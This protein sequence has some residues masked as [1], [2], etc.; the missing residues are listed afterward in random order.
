[1]DASTI[2]SVAD[3]YLRQFAAIVSPESM[4]NI[5]QEMRSMGPTPKNKEELLSVIL[6][7]DESDTTPAHLMRGVFFDHERRYPTNE[8]IISHIE[9]MYPKIIQFAKDGELDKAARW[10]GFVAGA[11][12]VEWGSYMNR[13]EGY[14]YACAGAEFAKAAV[15]HN[16]IEAYLHL[17][18]AQG[19]LWAI[20]AYTINELRGH[21]AP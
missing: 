10:L 11:T 21:N 7:E 15:T 16:L 19:T 14:G 8:D 1:M 17:G 5:K 12:L 3:H 6:G 18:F 20:G 9:A 13:R 4:A 2:V